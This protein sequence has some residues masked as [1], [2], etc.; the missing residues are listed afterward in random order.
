MKKK[1]DNFSKQIRNKGELPSSLKLE[2][3]QMS[4]N[5]FMIK[6]T[7]ARDTT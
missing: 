1:I 4:F 3:T 6:Q 5:E 7:V 2:I